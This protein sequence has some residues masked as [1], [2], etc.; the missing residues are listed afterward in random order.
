MFHF[1]IKIS[2]LFFFLFLVLLCNFCFSQGDRKFTGRLIF[3]DGN[4][5]LVKNVSVRLVDIGSTFTGTDGKFEIAINK[6]VGAVTLI[7]VNS[8]WDILYPIGGR[9]SI[10]MDPNQVIQF[11]IG[12]SPKD[13]LTKAVAK[14]N[15]EIKNKLTSL[16]VKQEGIEQTLTAFRDEIQK[17]A[18]IKMADLK[19]Q[20]DLASK[21]EQF[22]PILASAIN[23]YINEAK[24]LKDAFKFSANHAF[25][26]PQALQV[27]MDAVKSY[28]VA[29]EEINKKHT[30]YEKMVY[31]LWESESK[32]DEVKDFFSYALG[33]LHSANIFT[34]NLKIRDINEYNV[35]NL[36]GARKKAFKESVSREIESSVL[37]LERRLQEL[38]KRAQVIFTELAA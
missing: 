15:N 14:S 23:D 1:R 17:M 24:D 27:L 13:V 29:Y 21:R 3:L 35:G 26:D 7:L 20:I 19:D 10:P 8:D 4:Q 9:T 18:D 36:K 2:I 11:I 28:N 32:S 38:D 12:D 37:Q 16:G 25:D 6:N 31:D 34:L 5:N 33:E 30:G 22:F